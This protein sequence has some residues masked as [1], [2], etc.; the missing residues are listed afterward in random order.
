M[1]RGGGCSQ[2][3]SGRGWDSISPSKDERDRKG[4]H[5]G[6]ASEQRP[7]GTG[8]ASS[9][10]LTGCRRPEVESQEEDGKVG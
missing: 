7:E 10:S 3:G 9:L 5:L 2:A 1:S 8:Q 4:G 6:L